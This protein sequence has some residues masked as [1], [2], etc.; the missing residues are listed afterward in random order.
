MLSERVK[1]G[2]GLSALCATH[3]DSKSKELIRTDLMW[4]MSA[5]RKV[6]ASP[7]AYSPCVI[8]LVYADMYW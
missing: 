7:V 5:K 1:A 8:R 2:N 4:D 3:V 6:R